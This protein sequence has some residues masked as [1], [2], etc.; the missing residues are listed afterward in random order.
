MFVFTGIAK[1]KKQRRAAAKKQQRQSA[2][3]AERSRQRVP[4]YEQSIDLAAGDGTV[5]GA[6]VAGQVRD[7]LTR[8]MRQKRK[9]DIKESNF[10]KTMR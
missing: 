3:E 5:R 4:L 7:E 8:A 6:M 1:S 9:A 10:L 2:L